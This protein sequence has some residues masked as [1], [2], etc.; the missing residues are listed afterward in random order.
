MRQPYWH[1]P[2]ATLFA[3]RDVLAEMPARSVDCI[4]TSRP[5]WTP[6][7]D[8]PAQ[9]TGA[10]NYGFE[11]T[12]G[13]YVAALR[14][15]CAEAHR[16]LADDGTFW[17]VLSDRYGTQTTASSAGR[18]ARRL[19]DPSMTGLPA[20]CLIGLPWQVALALNDDGW[21]IRNAIVWDHGDS[22]VRTTDRLPLTYELIFL[23]TK[24]DH[25]DRQRRYSGS[26]TPE[27]RS[28]NAC[29]RG[30]RHTDRH[31]SGRYG[32]AIGR[33]RGGNDQVVAVPPGSPDAAAHGNE[34]G[35]VWTLPGR[36]FWKSMPVDVPLRCITAGCRQGGT[37]LDPFAGIAPTGIA[38]RELSRAFIGIEANAALCELAKARLSHA[39]GNA[40]EEPE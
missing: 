15:V 33:C 18:H 14:R 26:G 39:G 24:Q 11:A 12:P 29:R 34:P 36:S 19:I 5:P 35:D 37:V 10:G 38:A 9:E 27:C 16:V 40:A 8:P 2:T 3:G 23:L 22:G 25:I 7:D 32:S 4:V 6:H 13:L 21:L 28:S 17:L 1:D 20:S 31:G 30:T